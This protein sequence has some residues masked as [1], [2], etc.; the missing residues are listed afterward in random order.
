MNKLDT[1]RELLVASHLQANWNSYGAMPIDK[2]R[3]LSA[4]GIVLDHMPDDLPQPSVVPTPDSRIQF[5]WSIGEAWMEMVV[6]V[7][8]VAEIDY[9]ECVSDKCVSLRDVEPIHISDAF[10]WLMQQAK[11]EEAT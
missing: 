9:N 3:I 2:M 7:L 5:E 6:D 4:I 10:S 1:I 8:G 11:A